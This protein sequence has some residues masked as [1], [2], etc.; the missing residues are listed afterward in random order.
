VV[1]Y[2]ISKDEHSTGS[3]YLIILQEAAPLEP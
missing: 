2:Y 3:W 1:D